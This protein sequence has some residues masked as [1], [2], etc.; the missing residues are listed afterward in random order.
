MKAI[1]YVEDNEDTAAAV[2]IMLTHAGYKIDTVGC[3]K[4]ALRLV[5]SG[6]KF[7]LFLLIQQVDF[8]IYKENPRHR[9][10]DPFKKIDFGLGNEYI[11][12]QHEK[13]RIARLQDVNRCLGIV[14]MGRPESGGVYEDG[15]V[16]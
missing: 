10:N 11:R 12:A 15:P 3:G 13:R 14:R 8:V 6:K 1:L 16:L 4:D 7:D 9:G 5:A 2:K